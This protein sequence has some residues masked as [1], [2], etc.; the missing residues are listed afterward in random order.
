MR[1]KP[2]RMELGDGV[3]H[4]IRGSELRSDVCRMGN[5]AANKVNRRERLT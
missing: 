3:F 1:L 5:P 2:L 4:S